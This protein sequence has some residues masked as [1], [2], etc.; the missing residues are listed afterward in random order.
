MNSAPLY[1][2]PRPENVLR[3]TMSAQPKRTWLQRLGDR[4]WRIAYATWMLLGLPACIV[5]GAGAGLALGWALL[6]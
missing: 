3:T 5:S 1:A 4:K 2:P 6:H